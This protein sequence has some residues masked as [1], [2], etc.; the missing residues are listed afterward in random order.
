M[1]EFLLGKVPEAIYFALFMIFAKQIKCKR[2]LFTIL[3]IIEYILL[4]YIFHYSVWFH[5]LYT[6]ISFILMK[7]LY[8]EKSQITDIFIFTISSVILIIFSILSYSIMYFT[9]K[10][11]I[12]AS[13]L[14][15][16]LL[17]LFLLVFNNKLYN[18]QNM[19]KNLWNRTNKPKKIKSATFRAINIITFNILFY[20]INI[21]MILTLILNGGD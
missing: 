13:I 4:E 1:L 18:I 16:I 17:F 10:N 15:K 5:I 21:G 7:I 19:Y 8:K 12:L 20:V 9:F 6:F 2:I 14:E 11:L 3:M